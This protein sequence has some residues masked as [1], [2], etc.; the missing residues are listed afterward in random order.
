MDPE[1]AYNLIALVI[2]IVLS[3]FFSS[4]E[5]A[6]TSVSRVRLETLASVDGPKRKKA[7]RALKVIDNKQKMLSAI[8]I[9]NNL[10]NVF[11]SAL[12]TAT[13]IDL[14]GSLG[15][16]I[17]TGLLTLI[18]LV[19]GEIT[20]KSIAT[21][22]PTRLSLRI[23]GII[24]ILMWVLTPVIFIL[25]SIVTI[26]KR[27][28]GVSKSEEESKMTSQEVRTVVSISHEAG[29]IED[30]E[31]EYIENVFDFSDSLV[32]EV[33]TP[34]IDTTV[35]KSDVTYD[36]M[37][38]VFS[39]NMYTRYPVSKDNTD[40]IIGIF[41]IKDMIGFD[42]K[43]TFDIKKYL[44]EAHFTFEHKNTAELF[45][46]MRKGR[47]AMS[48]VL[49][50]YGD[51]AGIITLED[52]LEELVG[53]IR[54][55]FDEYE[56]DALQK[57]SEREFEVNGSMNLDDLCDELPLD[58]SSED[59]DTIGGYLVGLFDHFP[60]RGETYIT[61]NGISLCV[62]ESKKSRIRKIRIRFPKN[63]DEMSSDF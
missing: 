41:N 50:E 4:S 49:D 26:V 45:E 35:M 12:A 39:E 21:L 5:T 20:P 27:I 43:D 62:L 59:Y 47:I 1:L 34:R 44:R 55:E 37:V 63:V 15:L 29:E 36:E 22:E 9:G 2:L 31:K 11:A 17:A 7:K 13:A 52:L 48:I 33:M 25:N 14:F 32:R 57:L 51:L 58:F 60:K 54:D 56:E 40:E 8:L 30:D 23:S 28:F 42:K 38:K 61:K 53:E 3:A 19:F 18:I 16:G 24:L 6:L 46:E 10:V